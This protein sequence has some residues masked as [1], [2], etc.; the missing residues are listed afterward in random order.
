MG[1]SGFYIDK[2]MFYAIVTR[3]ECFIVRIR[4]VELE[5]LY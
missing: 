2:D 5:T 1:A 3:P 4:M